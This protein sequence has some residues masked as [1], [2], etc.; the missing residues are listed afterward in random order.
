MGIVV[1][2]FTQCDVIISLT[3]HYGFLFGRTLVIDYEVLNHKY[4]GACI[5]SMC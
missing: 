1:E 2:E 3:Y 5:L 4:I